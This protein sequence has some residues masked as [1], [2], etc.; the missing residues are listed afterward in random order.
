MRYHVLAT[1]FDGTLALN[2]RVDEST[3]KSLNK[4]LATGRRLV[5]V[6]GRELSELLAAFPEIDLFEWVVAENGGLLYHPSSK[7]ERLITDP[8]S[9]KL[10]DALHRQG[11]QP[12]SV[13]RSIVAT[14][15]PYETV[16]LETIRDLGLDL[17]VTFN[18][19][20]V[21]VL[22]AGV[23]KA[24]GLAAALK[25]MGISAHNAVGIGDAE[26]DHAFLRTCEFS[27]AVVNALPAVKETADLVTKS[28]HGAG[29]TELIELIVAN[30]LGSFEDRLKRHAFPLGTNNNEEVSLPSYGS[31]VLICGPSGSGKSTVARRIIEAITE[32]R[33]QFCLIDPEGDYEAIEGAVVL[34]SP[35]GIPQIEEV[36]HL[37][38]D[39]EANAVVCLTGMSIPDRPPFFL[40][41]MSQLLQMRNRTGHPHW[42]LLDEAHHLMPAEWLPSAGMIPEQL[43]NTLLITVQANLLAETLLEHVNTV[44]AVGADAHQTLQSFAIAANAGQPTFEE[45][46]LESGEILLW[47]RECA[48]SPIKVQTYPCKSQQQRHHRKYAEG[49]LPPDRS[50]YFH[51]PEGKLN[52]RAQNLMLFLQLAD[53]LDDATWEYH[54]RRGDYERWFL[55]SIK[56]DA[57]SAKAKR[58]AERPKTTAR[59]SRRLIRSAVEEN[60]TLP[61][62][63]PL[64]VP[65][66]S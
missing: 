48:S 44:I 9:E 64:P 7:E 11:V 22:P 49:E 56:D 12:V 52:L 18:K 66:A 14:W 46:C 57:L 32:R 29:V 47:R 65:G 2:G 16:V 40:K 25:E 23:T 53:G 59:E 19:G 39:S 6:T 10:I 5:M 51:G 8:P 63:L 20:A 54:L 1:D 38:E 15:H 34:G 60:Y 28:D 13:G 21:M 26:N 35:N 24:F 41:L 62:S 31:N 58:I 27:A 50:F 43:N 61:A 17:Q 3:L 37:L 45:T 30:D 42:L 36:V 33:Y 4:F 55:E